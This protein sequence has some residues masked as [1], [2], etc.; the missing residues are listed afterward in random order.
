MGFGEGAET[1]PFSPSLPS[2]QPF[3]LLAV[4]PPGAPH[5]QTALQRLGPE[6]PGVPRMGG[7]LPEVPWGQGE[8]MSKKKKP[9]KNQNIVAI[10]QE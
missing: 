9:P 8:K 6:P 2:P 1:I 3:G 5:L 7:A 4:K 10:A